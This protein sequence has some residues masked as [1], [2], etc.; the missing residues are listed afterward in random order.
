VKGSELYDPATGV[1]SLTGS[2]NEP[3]NTHGA[4]VLASGKVLVMGDAAL[5][6]TA[7]LYD[8]ERRTWERTAP[9]HSGRMYP[10]P[11]LLPSGRVLV[12]GG[13][14]GDP[15]KPS[16]ADLYDPATGTCPLPTRLGAAVKFILMVTGR[17]VTTPPFFGELETSSVWARAGTAAPA[18]DAAASCL[19]WTTCR[20]NA[21]SCATCSRSLRSSSTSSTC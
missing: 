7:E 3:R 2:L 11:V 16:S 15:A 5:S 1:W 9:M 10:Q 17:C 20:R 18:R 12:A 8:P 13:D 19:V 4:V 14:P 21:S 6:N